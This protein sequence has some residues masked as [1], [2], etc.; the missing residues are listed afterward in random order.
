L[1]G[2]A[3]LATLF[4]TRGSVSQLLVMYALNV[5]VTFSLTLAG[6][7]IH[8]WRQRKRDRTWRGEFAL[9]ATGLLLCVSILIVMVYEKFFEGGWVTVLVTTSLVTLAFL[10]RRHYTRVREQLRRLDDALLNIPVRPHPVEGS[11]IKRDEPV[12]VMLVNGFS[13]LGVHMVLSVQ[14]L[15]PHLYKAYLFVS[16]GVIDSS[17]FKG[18]AEIEAL[19]KRTIEE[20]EKY[21][22]FAHQLGFRAEYRYTIGREAVEQVVHLCEEVPREFP[23]SIFYLGQLVFENDRFYYRLLHNETAFSIQRRLQFAGLQAIVLP[24]RVLGT[25]KSLRKAS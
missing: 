7:T 17:H 5:F 15:F 21:V 22:Q 13:G 9:Q 16:A 18:V 14:N 25:R 4:Y 12:A 23:R 6:M 2:L 3:A 19:K 10:V 8:W 24:I 11:G 20:L 1:V